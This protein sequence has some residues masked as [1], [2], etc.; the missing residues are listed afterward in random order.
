VNLTNNLHLVREVKNAWSYISTPT[1]HLHG[2]VL[3][4]ST[5]ATL[6]SV[7]LMVLKFRNYEIL[8]SNFF[9]M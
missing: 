2:V 1:I 5:E 9:H 8:Q 6:R 4:L 3:S 7:L